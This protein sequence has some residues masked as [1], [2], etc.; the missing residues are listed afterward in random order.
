MITTKD[1]TQIVYP[2]AP[3]GLTDTHKDKVNADLLSFLS[4]PS[5]AV[6]GKRLGKLPLELQG[7]PCHAGDPR[8]LLIVSLTAGRHP[9]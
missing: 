2:G 1:G 6:T 3:H 5:V 7:W 8:G 9:A 4:R